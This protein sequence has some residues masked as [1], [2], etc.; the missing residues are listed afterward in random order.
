MVRTNAHSKNFTRTNKVLQKN[1]LETTV[2]N[3]MHDR[4][5]ACA[6]GNTSSSDNIASALRRVLDPVVRGG[7][8]V[9][10]RAMSHTDESRRQLS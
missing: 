6:V 2:L 7:S 8:I 3:L 10:K 5:Q 4:N 9:K 1:E